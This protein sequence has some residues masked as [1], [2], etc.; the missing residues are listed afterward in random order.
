MDLCSRKIFGWATGEHNDRERARRALHMTFRQRRMK[1]DG[2]IHPTD[3][4]SPHSSGDCTG[5]LIPRW[6]LPGMRR[7]GN[8]H[9]NAPAERSMGALRTELAPPERHS[10]R[11]ESC[12][13]IFEFIEGFYNSG[14]H[15]SSLGY[16]SPDEYERR[17]SV[18][19]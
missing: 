16:P 18:Q 10:T 19:A 1:L 12:R 6:I 8:C 3:R 2:L 5:Y 13:S 14:R 15:H 9:D 7:S 17:L 11:E 4:G